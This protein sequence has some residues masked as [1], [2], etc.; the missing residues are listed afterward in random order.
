VKKII[1]IEKLLHWAM[2]EELPKG[3]AVTASAWD[4]VSQYA[5]L[6]VRVD[7][8]YGGL[9]FVPGDPHPDAI[10]VADAIR[11][12]DTE[13]RFGHRVEV[14][15]LFGD[16]AA[17][18]GDAVDAVMSATFNPRAIVISK[19]TQ[20]TRP[21]WQFDEP[22]PRQVFVEAR[23]ARGEVRPMAVVHGVD[24]D[25]DLIAMKKNRGRAFKRDGEY[26]LAM[27]PRSPI[28]WCD[29]APLSIADA[30]AEYVAWHTALA[31]LADDLAHKL[32][33]HLPT[34]PTVPMLPWLAPETLATRMIY[35]DAFARFATHG[36]PLAPKRR[37]AG[38][39]VESPIEAETRTAYARASR[40]KMRKTPASAA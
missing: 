20:G 13:A 21:K 5:A 37:A 3:Q 33:D 29:P 17:I 40:E 22:E 9:G 30:R 14:L 31:T 10:I 16:L 39:P 26:N 34:G 12:L 27:S 1:D 15:P 2:R 24:A 23:N 8:S 25:G 6:G 4:I 35:R 32:E 36:L 28:E 38:K 11:D 7:V 19:A 18:A